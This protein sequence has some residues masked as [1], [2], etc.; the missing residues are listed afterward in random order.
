MEE[1]REERGKPYEFA[2]GM[3]EKA[4]MCRGIP[5]LMRHFGIKHCLDKTQNHPH[6]E[7]WWW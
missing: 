2:K 6:S 5:D 3:L 1:W 4:K 7:V